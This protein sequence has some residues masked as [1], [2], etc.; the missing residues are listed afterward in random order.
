M[1]Q[2]SREEENNGVEDVREEGENGGNVEPVIN[3][4]EALEDNN[5]DEDWGGGDTDVAPPQ[6]T[7]DLQEEAFEDLQ[8]FMGTLNKT[9]ST[10]EEPVEEDKELSGGASVSKKTT[11]NK[12]TLRGDTKAMGGRR[13]RGEK[14]KPAFI[15][16]LNQCVICNLN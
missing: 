2:E 12:R 13:T 1:I 14:S 8:S 5:Q 7:I 15:K 10:K 11:P 3:N 6:A 9:V 16:C 4:M